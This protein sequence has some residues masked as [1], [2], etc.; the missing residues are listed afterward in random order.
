[1]KEGKQ[2]E[3]GWRSVEGE[4]EKGERG[5]DMEREKEEGCIE[6]SERVQVYR[7]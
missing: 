6:A 1:M 3:M 4:G 5:D 7:S 2:W